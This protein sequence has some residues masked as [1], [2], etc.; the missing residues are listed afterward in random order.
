[1]DNQILD[2]SAGPALRDTDN[3]LSLVYSKETQ[4]C[5]KLVVIS[6]SWPPLFERSNVPATFCVSDLKQVVDRR[7]IVRCKHPYAIAGRPMR[8]GNRSSE[9]ASQALQLVAHAF[10]TG[11]SVLVAI[12][13]TAEAI[14]APRVCRLLATNRR[15]PTL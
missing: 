6:K 12:E 7:R 11:V 15:F 1:M 2:E 3:V 4:L 9:I 5:G 10:P 8:L 14:R 13:S